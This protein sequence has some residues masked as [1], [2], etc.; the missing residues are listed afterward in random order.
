MDQTPYFLYLAG[1]FLAAVVGAIPPLVGKWS[2]R[3]LHRFVA[4]GA[5]VFL[6]AVFFHLVPESVATYPGVLTELSLLSG[7]MLVLFVERVL[8]RHRHVDCEE[9]ELHRH[10]VMSLSAFLGL[11]L[12]S[13]MAGLAL[14]AG[15]TRSG[16]SLIIFLAIVSHKSVAAFSLATVFRLAA[17]PSR[18]VLTLLLIFALITPLGAL[19]SLPLLNVLT[20]VHLAIPNSLAAGSFIYVATMDLLPEA[21][22]DDKKRLGTF[23]FLSLGIAL[24]WG[25]RLLGL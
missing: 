12:H 17:L 2:D 19:I 21:F 16:S 3:Q 7:F 1:I 11:S 22:H 13:L 23:I 4:L 6:G 25:L 24:M 14:G 8:V 18:R 5:G 20:E 15:L 10:Q 9:Q